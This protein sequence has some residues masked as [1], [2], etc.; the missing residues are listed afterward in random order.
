MN[1][2]TAQQQSY[3]LNDREQIRALATLFESGKWQVSYTTAVALILTAERLKPDNRA[4][5]M[6]TN[7]GLALDCFN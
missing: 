5:H 6:E 1:E 2:N 4:K 7:L 3:D